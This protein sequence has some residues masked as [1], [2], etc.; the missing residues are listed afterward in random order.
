M[1]STVDNAPDDRSIAAQGASTPAATLGVSAMSAHRTERAGRLRLKDLQPE[2]E[3]IRDVR[4]GHTVSRMI[5]VMQ[6]FEEWLAYITTH[7]PPPVSQDIAP[8]GSTYF[9]G[10]E[11]GDVIV[12]LT[13]STVTVWEYAVSLETPQAPAVEPLRVGSVVWRRIPTAHAMSAVQSLI[14][15]ARVSRRSKFPMCSQCERRSPPEWM[16]DDEVCQSCAQRDLGVA[17]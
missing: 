14:D 2:L 5:T 6:N 1:P 8:D 17:Y 4:H 10:G 7:L 15:A 3:R 13:R 11:P 12:R 16:H 9:T